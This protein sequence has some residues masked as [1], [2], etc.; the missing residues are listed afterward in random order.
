LI[1]DAAYDTLPKATRA[2]LHERFALWLEEHGAEL[3]EL[4]E[5]AGWHL[6]Q[7][8]RYR[9]ELGQRVDVKAARRAG[10]HLYSG[11]R[12]AAA[13]TDVAAAINLLE[14]ALALVPEQDPLRPEIAVA[15]AEQMVDA[16]EFSRAEELLLTAE[17]GPVQGPLAVLT[18]LRSMI[19]T[20]ASDALQEMGVSLGPL[21]EQVTQAGDERG[22]AKAHEM[23]FLRYVMASQAKPAAEEAR[24]A[25]L[26][27]ARAG[28]EALNARAQGWHI[29]EL[30]WGPEH[31]DTI[32]REVDRIAQEDR[33]PYLDSF[34]DYG[35]GEVARLR[36]ELD[37]GREL[38]QRG[39]EK[40][41]RLGIRA[42][43][44][45]GALHLSLLEFSAVRPQAAVDALARAD[46]I[47]SELGER[48]FRS[49]VQAFL[50]GAYSLIPDTEAALLACERAEELSA[51]ED[52]VNFVLVPTV[53]A[54][55]ARL[56][57]DS[58]RAERLARA[59]LEAAAKIDNITNSTPA[60]L[61]LA[62]ALVALG[63]QDEAAV[64]GRKA[65]ALYETKGDQ[66]GMAVARTFLAGL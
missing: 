37:A 49:T 28:D 12:R 19:Q 14:R 34:I 66:P 33:G 18:R 60:H 51:P 65:L 22:I 35:H 3:V 41:E 53:R 1:R 25:A 32:E 24:L 55:L 8:L 39:T 16:G 7:A 30:I 59:A 17:D 56:E 47:L 36:G 31:V 38:S 52:A 45:A 44:A 15:L 26:H 48:S 43:A 13:R 54:R 63:R 2:D 64:E 20:R 9:R 5:I 6:E 27:A 11:G 21:L 62:H 46:K 10:E 42:M 61:E 40:L 58:K 57:G 4:D 29:T 50:A 23:L